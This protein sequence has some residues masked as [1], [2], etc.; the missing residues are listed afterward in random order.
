M[1]KESKVD[2]ISKNQFGMFTLFS[3]QMGIHIGTYGNS[4]QLLL[5]QRVSGPRGD[6]LIHL[7]I[8]G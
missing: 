3:V 4:V 8:I 6:T 7:V 2:I 5:Q 1:R